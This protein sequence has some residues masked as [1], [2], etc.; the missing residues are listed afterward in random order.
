MALLAT[1]PAAA[2]DR[3]V[4]TELA[5]VNELQARFTQTQ[6]RAILKQ[7]LVSEGTV[8]FE[9]GASRLAWDVTSPA[10]STFTMDGAKAKMD[11]PDLKMSETIDLSQVPDA[12]RL[13]TSM[14]VWM[15]ADPA[16]VERD[17]DAVYGDGFATLRPRDEKLRA[18]IAELRIHFEEREG[19][20]RVRGVDLVE[21]DGD[22]VEISFRQVVLDGRPIPDAR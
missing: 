19:P 18:L 13:A 10:R 1:G 21:P 4:W 8:R 20:V 14:L 15:R 12:S 17:F 2:T 22:R 16:A 11:Y 9:R 7:P 6:Y 5:R 3:D